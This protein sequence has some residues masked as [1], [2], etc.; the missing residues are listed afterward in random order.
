M[1]VTHNFTQCIDNM[2]DLKMTIEMIICNL[3]YRQ[4]TKNNSILIG[5]VTTGKADVW[6]TF[7]EI[8]FVDT[9][10]NRLIPPLWEIVNPLYHQQD[11]C[12]QQASS[13]SKD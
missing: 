5:V 4:T 9:L 2:H 12:T 6:R 11:A 7:L 8:G 3:N 1:Y 10:S 13:Y